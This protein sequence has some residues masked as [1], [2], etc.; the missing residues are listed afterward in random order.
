ML[1]ANTAKYSVLEKSPLADGQLKL[2]YCNK[3]EKELHLPECCIGDII[4]LFFESERLC[5]AVT[6][7][8]IVALFV[9]KHDANVRHAGELNPFI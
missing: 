6:F 2:N 4:L 1:Y 5:S 9:C 7:S 8:F 3:E